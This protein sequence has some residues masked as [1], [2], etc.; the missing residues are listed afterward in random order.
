MQAKHPI[1]RFMRYTWMKAC[2]HYAYVRG[3]GLQAIERIERAWDKRFNAPVF[4]RIN[5]GIIW[6]CEEATPADVQSALSSWLG[7]E[8]DFEF[9]FGQSHASMWAWAEN[10]RRTWL[11]AAGVE[12]A[13]RVNPF[14]NQGEPSCS[15]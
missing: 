8:A 2:D 14:I 3:P 15:T 6:W 5:A 10:A 7:N 4:R 1:A 11:I 9:I 13:P 12:P